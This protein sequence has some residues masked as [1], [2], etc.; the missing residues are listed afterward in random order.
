MLTPNL[1]YLISVTKPHP[2]KTFQPTTTYHR[3]LIHRCSQ[4]YKC[5]PEVDTA[6]KTITVFA[7]VDSRMY[8]LNAELLSDWRLILWFCSLLSLSRHYDLRT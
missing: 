2:H 1:L 6:L 4:Y 7:V 3:L 8:V 5:T